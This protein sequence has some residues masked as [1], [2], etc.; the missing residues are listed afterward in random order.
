MCS[1]MHETLIKKESIFL[2]FSKYSEKQMVN[3]MGCFEQN[4]AILSNTDK[5]FLFSS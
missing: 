1:F 5:L 4:K 2:K 3:S